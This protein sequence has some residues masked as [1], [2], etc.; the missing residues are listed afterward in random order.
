MLIGLAVASSD[1]DMFSDLKSLSV[2]CTAMCG[3]H[4]D[5]DA[6]PLLSLI[7]VYLLVLFFHMFISLCSNYCVA[8]RT[9]KFTVL[10]PR[11]GHARRLPVL[12]A[13]LSVHLYIRI[14]RSM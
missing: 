2:L 9:V 12:L 14:V 3:E 4:S 13:T 6:C 10:Q 7:A 11:A 1:V 8:T 5:L